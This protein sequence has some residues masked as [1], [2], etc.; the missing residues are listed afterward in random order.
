MFT[1]IQEVV[2]N[3]LQFL[4]LKD[5]GQ[6]S[7]VSKTFHRAM[8][9]VL[10]NPAFACLQHSEDIKSLV[11]YLPKLDIYQQILVLRKHFLPVM[12]MPL[13]PRYSLHLLEDVGRSIRQR[14]DV[15]LNLAPIQVLAALGEWDFIRGILEK[16]KNVFCERILVFAIWVICPKIRPC[17]HRKFWRKEIYKLR[18]RKL[19]AIPSSYANNLTKLQR[20]IVNL[21]D[22]LE[23]NG[24]FI[25]STFLNS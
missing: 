14:L 5:I 2:A 11:R 9:L 19:T 20:K 8:H 24:K 23:V 1:S 6:A 4:R 17:K 13:V 21:L 15:D 18:Y 12:H 3:C 10:Q 7:L 16:D 25:F 22:V